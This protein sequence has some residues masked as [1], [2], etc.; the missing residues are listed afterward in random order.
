MTAPDST[1]APAHDATAPVDQPHTQTVQPTAHPAGPHPGEEPRANPAVRWLTLLIGLILLALTAVVGRDLWYFFQNGNS[2]D[3]WLRPVFEFVGRA[4][5]DV[6][7]V[8]VGIIIAIIGLVLIVYAFVPRGR[9]HVRVDSP[10]SIWTRPVDIARKA[11]HTTRAEV[12]NA[13]IQSRAD[14]KKL[15]VQ[16]EDDGSGA[17]LQERLTSVLSGEFQRLTAPP[18]ISVKVTP[19]Q[20]ST[21]S[22]GNQTD[23]AA[24]AYATP[25]SAAEISQQTQGVQ[26]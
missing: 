26:R 6:T 25:E 15:R 13:R 2:D 7:A 11:T 23:S 3:S 10:A 19:K 17:A 8:T 1:S 9:T 14:R 20:Q 24:D 12:G 5:M 4:T 21:A 18:A 16:V 22:A